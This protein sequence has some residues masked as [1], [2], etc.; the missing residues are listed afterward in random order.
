MYSDALIYLFIY[1]IEEPTLT[2]PKSL[3]VTQLGGGYSLLW[4]Q[5][6]GK[7]SPFFPHI[8]SP[9]KQQFFFPLF[10]LNFPCCILEL[11]LIVLKNN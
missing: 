9:T 1:F 5:I 3:C 8:F 4:A 6:Y 10:F 2:E 7:P 11:G